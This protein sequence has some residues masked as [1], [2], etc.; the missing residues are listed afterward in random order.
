MLTE[1]LTVAENDKLQ[2]LSGDRLLMA[3]GVTV[4]I[5]GEALFNPEE[6]AYILPA[7]EDV[8]PRGLRFQVKLLL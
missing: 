1:D 4:S 6:T 3:D 5:D 7:G 2:I 8:N